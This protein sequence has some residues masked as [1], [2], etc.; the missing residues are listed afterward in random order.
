VGPDL[1]AHVAHLRATPRRPGAE[2]GG[3]SRCVASSERV[4][5]EPA[6]G[7]AACRLDA[8]VALEV[9]EPG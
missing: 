4:R 1:A 7:R 3:G 5:A 6:R 9:R 2:P 8:C